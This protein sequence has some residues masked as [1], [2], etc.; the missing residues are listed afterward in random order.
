MLKY[1]RPR[2]ARPP[3]AASPISRAMPDC[4]SSGHFTASDWLQDDA[5]YRYALLIG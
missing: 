3:S 1:E 2:R 4:S 5:F